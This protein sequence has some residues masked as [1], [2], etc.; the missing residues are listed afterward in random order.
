MSEMTP[1]NYCSMQGIKHRA[2]KLNQDVLEVESHG[3]LGGT[4]VYIVPKGMSLEEVLKEDQSPYFQAWFW[5]LPD[6][7]CC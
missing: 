4:D 2:K 6:H 7:C 3:I 1:C 5:E